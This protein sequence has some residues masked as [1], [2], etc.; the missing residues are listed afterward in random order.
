MSSEV[1]PAPG[2]AL[3]WVDNHYMLVE[4]EIFRLVGLE[5]S[6]KIGFVGSFIDDFLI[7]TKE[8][9]LNPIEDD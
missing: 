4:W 1:K 9:P 5:N 8:A 2:G 3:I 6:A 7:I